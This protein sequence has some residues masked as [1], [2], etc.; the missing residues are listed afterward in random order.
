MSI[1]NY[2]DKLLLKNNLSCISK[3]LNRPWGGFYVI[4]EILSEEFFNLF[5]NIEFK[6]KIDFQSKLSPKI[7]V[8]KPNKRLSW[9]YHHRR[10][11]VW[12]IIKGNILVSKSL[13]DK[14]VKPFKLNEKDQINIGKEIRH[15]IIGTDDYALVAEIWIHTDKSN[16][17]D[18]NDIIRLQ[19]DFNRN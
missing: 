8:I 2:V 16:P 17:S 13:D 1:F 12:S 3:D 19:D 6:N 9:Q 10:S 11:E 7:L 5:F 18:E 15:R 4:N 14:E